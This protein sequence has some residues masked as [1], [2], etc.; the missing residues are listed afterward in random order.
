MEQPRPRQRLV[1]MSSDR[2]NAM[3]EA[4]DDAVA[5]VKPKLRGWLPAGT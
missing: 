5:V 2:L 1:S 4:V 3:G